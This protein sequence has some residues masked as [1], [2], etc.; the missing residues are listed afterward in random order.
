MKIA[1]VGLGIIGGSMAMAIKKYTKHYVIGINRTKSTLETAFECGAIDEI[2]NDDS[3]SKADIIIL[4]LYPAITVDF[5]ERNC[6]KIKKGAIVADTSGIKSSI[7]P[8]LNSI[9]DK[10]NFT[11][12][13]T[14]PMAGKETSGFASADAEL[15]KGASFIVIPGNAP[16]D[17]VR[18]LCDLATQIGFSGIKFTTSLEHDQMIAYTSQLPHVLACAYVLSPR[19]P[20]HNGFSAGSY[21]DVSRVAKINATLWSGLFIENRDPLVKEI[22]TLINNLKLI[23]KEIKNNNSKELIDILNKSRKIKEQ[24]D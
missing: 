22:D 23:Q 11:F 19:C 9:A 4:T 24:F 20:H 14:H 12:I 3:L 15:F 8:K 13:G 6:N 21:C 16:Q 1:I 18:T 10:N 5:V 17:K 7:C 2:G